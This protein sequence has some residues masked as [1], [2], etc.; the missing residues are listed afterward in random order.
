MHNYRHKLSN[1]QQHNMQTLANINISAI[2]IS[3]HYTQ[4]SRALKCSNNCAL[5]FPFVLIDCPYA[6]INKLLVIETEN[7]H[8]ASYIQ[9][10]NSSEQFV[11]QSSLK[12]THNV[13]YL[14]CFKIGTELVQTK[15]V[16]YAK[17]CCQKYQVGTDI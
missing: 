9:W 1:M 4:K 3:S 7:Q 6:S 5:N 14:L 15:P 16:S 10:F 11:V 12:H 17:Q 8:N 2:N 13:C